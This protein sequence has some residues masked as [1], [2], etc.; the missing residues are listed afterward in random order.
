MAAEQDPTAAER[1]AQSF[2]NL[3]SVQ[4]VEDFRGSMLSAFLKRRSVEGVIIGGGSPCQENVASSPRS[5][6]KHYNSI[7]RWDLVIELPKP[8][9]LKIHPKANIQDQKLPRMFTFAREFPHPLDGDQSGTA[10]AVTRF[11]QDARRFPVESYEDSYPLR[12][13]H[14]SWTT[15]RRGVLGDPSRPFRG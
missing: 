3:I 15:S 12:A 1:A 7:M 6:I 8:I 10:Q 11:E 5:V 14:G 4:Y 2:P 13:R 9:P